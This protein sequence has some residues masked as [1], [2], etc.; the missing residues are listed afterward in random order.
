MADNLKPTEVQKDVVVS[1]DYILKVDGELIDSSEE[2]GP[3]QFIQGN[4]EI[5][6]GLERDIEGMKLDETR[7]L[8][9]APSDA[10]GE[11]DPE[12][13]VDVPLTDFPQDLPIEPGTEIEVR[14]KDGNSMDAR[15]IE[16]KTDAV[17]L[18]FNHPLAG[19][20]LDFHVKVVGLRD[21]TE[22]EREHGHVHSSDHHHTHE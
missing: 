6:P 2:T 5:I 17:T 16:V 1:L 11:M 4:G 20:E 19:K 3:I 18:D 10:Y 21:S 22:E 14:D 13:V 7:D 12:A 8:R 15:I 9:I